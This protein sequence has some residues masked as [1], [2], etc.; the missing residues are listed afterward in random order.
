MNVYVFLGPTMSVDDAR[1]ILPDA[2]YL[3]PAAQ[4]DI[5]SLVEQVHPDAILLIDGVFT[6]ALSVWHKEILYALERGVAFY[7]ASSMGALRAAE[8]A[9]YG[10]IGVGRIFDGYVS[11]QL[12]DDDEVAV[13]HST[14]D[15]G[16]RLLSEAMV[17]IRASLAAARDTGVIDEAAHDQLVG[18]AKQRFYP[19]RSYPQLLADAAAAGLD[20]STLTALRAFLKT[21]AIDQKR[22][23]AIA[24]LTLIRDRGPAAPST[25]PVTRSHV[26]SAMYHRDRRVNRGG[27]QVPLSDISSYTALHLPEFDTF[28]EHALHSALVDVLAEVMNVEATSDD[29][30]NE[31]N[32]FCQERRLGTPAEV[33]R[34]CRENDLPEH[35]FDELLTRL[36]VR[37][38]LRDWF[39]SRKYLERTTHEVL[40]ELRIRSRY[41]ELA[42]A[43]ACQQE[44]L[45]SAH[46]DF[47]HNGNDGDAVGLIRDQMGNT[48]WNPRVPLNVWAFES[49][50]K[51]AH[52]VMYE[53]VRAQLARRATSAALASLLGADASPTSDDARTAHA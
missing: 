15:M 42:D 24:L 49:G 3:P 11:G 26:F 41:P 40:T 32:R 19:E 23:D 5:L 48:P 36:A 2:T 50:F 47:E 16:H 4:S 33:E 46:P 45:A 30:A 27:V 28:N 17:N 53:L 52:D 1:Q 22:E 35:Q 13:V 37:R 38:R 39:V 14:A 29:L 21:S 44:I 20:P 8:T 31:R 51:N 34:W 12:T 10:A 7:G 43:T 9:A 18:L 25:Q 6:Q